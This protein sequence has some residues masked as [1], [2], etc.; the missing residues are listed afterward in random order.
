MSFYLFLNPLQK[1]PKF[2]DARPVQCRIKKGDALFI[3]AFWWHEVQSYPSEQNFN[4]A[5][6]FWL[7]L[8]TSVVSIN[9]QIEGFSKVVC[10]F[11]KR[12]EFSFLVKV[13]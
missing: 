10:L 13:I 5:I 7:V 9:K 11:F 3:P 2:A 1:F 4:L 6:N 12:F 8:G